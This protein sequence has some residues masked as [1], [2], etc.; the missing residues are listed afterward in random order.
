MGLG[1]FFEGWGNKKQQ[2]KNLKTTIRG[3]GHW[4][5]KKTH[6]PNFKQLKDLKI[7]SF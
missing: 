1:D 2:K 7:L 6:I 4:E 3:K 5:Q